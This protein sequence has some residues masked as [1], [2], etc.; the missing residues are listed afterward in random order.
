M[1]EVMHAGYTGKYSF[2]LVKFI[3]CCMGCAKDLL[4]WKIEKLM[5]GL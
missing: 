3:K 5:Q 4:N 1:V 2:S